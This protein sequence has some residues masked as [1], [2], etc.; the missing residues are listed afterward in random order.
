[1]YFSLRPFRQQ[2]H[3]TLAPYEE[4]KEYMLYL[5]STS[6]SLQENLQ[7][8]EMDESGWEEWYETN[9]RFQ[10]QKREQEYQEATGYAAD[11]SSME[12]ESCKS[13]PVLASESQQL[14]CSRT[15]FGSNLRSNTKRLSIIRI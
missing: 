3:L 15:L 14:T 7:L 11:D 12:S 8:Q 10:L 6:S 1:M 4:W 13:M 2:R 5:T 9:K